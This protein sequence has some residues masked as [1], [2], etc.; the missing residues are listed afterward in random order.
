MNHRNPN[1][2]RRIASLPIAQSDR[3]LALQWV[4][5]GDDLA[6]LILAL[7]RLFTPAPILK[8]TH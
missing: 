7:M 2:E 1:I 3:E 4:N 8:H 5:A 6:C